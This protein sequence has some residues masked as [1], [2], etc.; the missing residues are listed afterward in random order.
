VR[1][2]AVAHV[3]DGEIDRLVGAR[4]PCH[5]RLFVAAHPGDDEAGAERLGELDAGGADPARGAEHE[6]RL[7]GLE[8]GAVAEGEMRGLVDQPERGAVDEAEALGHG[9]AAGR[10]RAQLLGIG[11]ILDLHRDA[12]AGGEVGDARTDRLDH[13]RRRLARRERERRFDLVGPLDHHDVGK[14]GFGRLHRDH[15]LALPRHRVGNLLDRGVG[16]GA[17]ALDH[18]RPHRVRKLRPISCRWT[19]LVPSQIWVILASRISRSTL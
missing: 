5:A 16:E 14:V 10:R 15:H 17:E 11:A 2:Q 19:W 1:A 3:V 6:H 18:H 8:T 12:V 13:P 4:R 7:A 9:E